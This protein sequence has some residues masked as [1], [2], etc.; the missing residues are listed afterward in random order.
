VGFSER[1]TFPFLPDLNVDSY[2]P[3]I[4]ARD[5][6]TSK[7]MTTWTTTKPTI[8]AIAKKCT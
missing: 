6:G 1:V 7:A 5:F 8:A 3:V 2:L 4:M